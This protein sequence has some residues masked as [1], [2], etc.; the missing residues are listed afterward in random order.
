M[1][2]ILFAIGDIHG[3][4]GKLRRLIKACEAYCGE[5]P[6]RYVFLGDYIDRGPASRGVIEFL[7]R[8]QRERP[9]DVT[10]LRGNHEAMALAAHQYDGNLPMWLGNGGQATRNS[11]WRTQGWMPDEH[12]DWI[13]TLPLCHD[14]GLRF[15]V[16]AGVDLTRPLDQQSED[17]LL[18]M[19]EPFLTGSDHIDCGRYV[20]HGHTPQMTGEPDVRPHRVNLDT[21]AVFGGPLTAGVFDDTQARPH[22]FVTDH[23]SLLARLTGRFRR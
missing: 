12:R 11:Y 3:C 16:H 9:D 15:F 13:G 5:R 10:C 23:G 14:D 17:D 21:G 19:R 4:F 1:S 2:S 22:G 7:L 18:W 8:F 20:V 6:A